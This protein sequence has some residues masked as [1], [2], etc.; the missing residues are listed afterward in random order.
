[1]DEIDH[2]ANDRGP[3]HEADDEG[4]G[5]PAVHVERGMTEHETAGAAKNPFQQDVAEEV[6]GTA[7]DHFEQCFSE[8]HTRTRQGCDQKGRMPQTCSEAKPR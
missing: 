8:C 2:A 6:S 3:D 5:A 1:M 4:Q 7:Q